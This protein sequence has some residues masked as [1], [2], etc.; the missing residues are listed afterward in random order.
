LTLQYIFNSN[1]L[2][3]ALMRKEKTEIKK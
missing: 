3:I 2:Y 1:L